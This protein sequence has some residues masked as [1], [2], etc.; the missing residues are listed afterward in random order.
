[1]TSLPRSDIDRIAALLECG[2]ASLGIE[3]GSTRIKACLIDSATADVIAV[4]AFEWAST[5]ENGYWTYDLDD[6]RTG[7]RATYANLADD[8]QERYGVRPTTFAALG[9]SAMMHGYLAFDENDELL[10]PFRTWRNTTTA[11]AAAELSSALGF[12][13]PQR[14]SVAHFYQA[15]L[16]GEAHV[17][18]IAWTTTLA[19]Y[20]HFQLTGE[21]VLGVGDA[22]GMF[23]IGADGTTYDDVRLT[24]LAE[25]LA[26]RRFR[27]N[28]ATLLPAIHTAGQDAGSLTEAGAQFLDPTGVLQPGI[29]LCPPEGDAG[30]GMVATGAVAPRTGNVSAGT[31]TFAMVVLEHPLATS[32]PEIDVV[33]TPSGQPV[34]MVHL[35][36]GASEIAEWV[37][38]FREWA[39][40]AGASIE[41]DAAFAALLDSAE[42][43]APDAGGLLMYN[44]TAGEPVVDIAAGRPLFARR[45]D[46]TMTLANFARAQV[47]GVYAALSVGM[48]LLADDGVELDR[49]FAHGGMFRTPGAA[50]KLLAAA[51]DTPV[52]VAHTAS[53]GGAWGIAIL[54]AYRAV[55]APQSL[56]TFVQSA[57]FSHVETETV[58]PELTDVSGYAEF[59]I[60]Y[61]AGLELARKASYSI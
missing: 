59:M 6:V 47:F 25:L 22:S 45:P 7:V 8:C 23:P 54:A 42:V 36:N 10:S 57:V 43:A 2:R 1:M 34:A 56:E 60:H 40:A 18:R 9:V 27:G 35:N 16:D 20:V 49:M 55:E 26:E 4:G 38:L 52:T 17:P 3:L 30:T 58:I 28:Y 41:S 31:S 15:V 50:Q 44:F 39:A 21:K 48:Q 12:N 5:F 32:R 29:P 14:W 46:S 11:V 19:G 33:A 51:L 53:E 61:R 37:H 13:I 24:Q